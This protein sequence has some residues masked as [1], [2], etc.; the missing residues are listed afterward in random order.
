MPAPAG[1]FKDA[2]VSSERDAVFALSYELGQWVLSKYSETEADWVALKESDKKIE[3]MG[4]RQGRAF[5]F[6]SS[7]G[8]ISYSGGTVKVQN[9]REL[10]LYP[11]GKYVHGEEVIDLY[12]AE[13]L[14]HFMLF[15]S[16]DREDVYKDLG[17]AKIDRF[18]GN[19][20][21]WI[22][23]ETYQSSLQAVS[24]LIGNIH[25]CAD[26]TT[27]HYDVAGKGL[28]SIKSLRIRPTAPGVYVLYVLIAILMLL[29]LN[30]IF[31]KTKGMTK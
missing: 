30:E 25:L 1:E 2:A 4:V 11:R 24:G 20:S 5:W 14:R 19:T 26:S 12:D 23:P 28:R 17:F 29:I 15:Y 6:D 16:P 27:V 10:D 9:F 13:P 31:K 22:I 7:T 21:F 3:L 18:R 8:E